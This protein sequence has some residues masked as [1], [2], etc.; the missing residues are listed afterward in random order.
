MGQPAVRR[1]GV[2]PNQGKQARGL[3]GDNDTRG[4]CV[5]L[6]ATSVTH[7]EARRASPADSGR[8]GMATSGAVLA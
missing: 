2:K 6:T 5:R 7:Q 8:V 3:S 4:A 1:H